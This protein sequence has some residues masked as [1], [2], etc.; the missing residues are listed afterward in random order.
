MPSESAVLSRWQAL[1]FR[2]LNANKRKTPELGV[3]QDGR[4]LVSYQY[5][6]DAY[7]SHDS[8]EKKYETEAT[9]NAYWAFLKNG[10]E[11]LSW[12]FNHELVRSNRIRRH[13]LGSS[14]DSQGNVWHKVENDDCDVVD[15]EPLKRDF[16][17]PGIVNVEQAAMFFARPVTDDNYFNE[18]KGQYAEIDDGTPPE[19]FTN[20]F[21][22]HG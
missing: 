20:R 6:K 2:L 11:R 7:Y 19:E 16:F 22:A 14:H 8:E 5:S 21:N 18:C 12:F 15:R 17:S 1:R 3:S 10:H 4:G 13:P 9:V